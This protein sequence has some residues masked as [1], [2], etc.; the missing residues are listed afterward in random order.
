MCGLDGARLTAALLDRIDG[1]VFTAGDNAYPHGRR[2]DFLNC[3]EPHW[4]RHKARTRPSPGNHEYDRDGAAAYFEYFGLNAGP[5]GRGYYSFTA[6][7]WLVLSLNSNI[8]SGA[9]SAQVHWLR[10][11]LESQPS[12][13]IAAIW[14]HPVASSGLR[15]GGDPRMR[16]IF[17]VLTEFNADI[18]LAGHEHIYERFTRIDA[19]GFPSPTG[20]RQFIVGTGGADLYALGPPRPGSEAYAAVWGVLKLTLRSESY[21]WEFVSVDGESFRDQGMDVCR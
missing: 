14:H 9:G 15:R 13:C 21:E 7:G 16:E 12:R 20:I 5:P 17:R 6:G 19:D 2:E 8:A 10:Q 4:G 3:Y 1:I 11:Q 18:V